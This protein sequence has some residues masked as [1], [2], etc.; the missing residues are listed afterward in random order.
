MRL[1]LA[2]AAAALGLLAGV[3]TWALQPGYK[4]FSW[5]ETLELEYLVGLVP[6]SVPAGPGITPSVNQGQY[7]AALESLEASISGQYH[8]YAS[9]GTMGNRIVLQDGASAPLFHE[10]YVTH[11][12][13]AARGVGVSHGRLP[14]PAELGVVV[15][16]N[17][18]A[19]ELFGDPAQAVGVRAALTSAFSSEEVTIIGVLE[20]SPRQSPSVDVDEGLIGTLAHSHARNP[21]LFDLS[22]L[23]L[24]VDFASRDEAQR[25]LPHMTDWAQSFFGPEG[26]AVSRVQTASDEVRGSLA[27]TRQQVQARRVTFIGFGAL[28]A[29]AALCALY[30]QA[31]FRL[32]RFRQRLGVE[33]ALGATR[34]RLAVRLLSAELPWGLAG[35]LA[36]LAVLM[37]LPT[38]LPRMFLTP[39]PLVVLVTSVGVPVAALLLLSAVVSLPLLG[40]S[41]MTLI[42]GPVRDSRVR[43]I[44]ALVYAGLT[45][46]LGGGLVASQIRSQVNTEISALRAQF[47]QV[48]ALQTG[49]VVVDQRLER[50]FESS[51]GLE[52]TFVQTDATALAQLPGVAGATISQPLPTLAVAIE[53]QTV[54]LKASAADGRYLRFMGLELAQGNA[55]GCVVSSGASSAGGLE[56]GS[57]LRLESIGG[58]LPCEVTG[59]MQDPHELWPWL[60]VDL[61]QLVVPPMDGLGVPLPGYTAQPFR[62]MRVLL[63][64]DDAAAEAGVRRWLQSTHPTAGAE[65]IPYTPD[66][67]ELLSRLRVQAELF[68][69]IALLAAAL[70]VWGIVAG[71]LALLEAERFKIALDR[72]L[73]LTV[74]RLTLTWWW[75]TAALGLVSGA[76]DVALAQALTV[77]LYNALA[78]DVA[79]LPP[80]A[81]LPIG[82]GLASAAAAL[83][84]LLST[85][86]AF[87][88]ARWLGRSSTLAQ[89]KE[90]TR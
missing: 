78:L 51:S 9:M 60:V 46:A 76:V 20:P 71:F 64:L 44:L 3:V 4:A 37:A 41:A 89:L 85:F 1:N 63:R 65:L 88:T 18:L 77:R 33:K 7:A 21:H 53:G 43:P 58:T 70:S 22:P 72:A 11:G 5:M 23:F 25:L 90:G 68:Q 66:V 59:I 54:R 82:L 32:L 67:E 50:A 16:G 31:F 27:Q 49:S 83:L 61:P 52:H 14:Q 87:V 35:G 19:R 79:S 86:L 34:T 45:L 42:R 28:L 40:R 69:L 29:A 8:A 56:L 2:V 30:A 13:Y 80:V 62:S 17:Q 10:G 15:L 57:M 39:P 74:R 73:G 12:Y 38:L 81:R 47:G 36:A 24:S 48:F 6:G 26:S 55:S 84:L 75:R